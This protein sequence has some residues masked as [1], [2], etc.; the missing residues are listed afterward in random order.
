MSDMTELY[1]GGKRTTLE[2]FTDYFKEMCGRRVNGLEVLYNAS[3]LAHYAQTS[4]EAGVGLPPPS[5]LSVVFDNF[6]LDHSLLQDGGMMEIAGGQCLLLA[7]FFCDQMRR[8][9]AIH[10]Y[11]ERGASFFSRAAGL[12]RNPRK[13]ALLNRM[14]EEFEP[15]RRRHARLSR[16]LRRQPHLTIT[17]PPDK[18]PDIIIP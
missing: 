16:M 8:R 6:V 11:A 1:E 5:N 18:P 4:T 13:S 14:A 7:G 2:F 17:P 12:N 9:Y 3:V 15:W 10:E